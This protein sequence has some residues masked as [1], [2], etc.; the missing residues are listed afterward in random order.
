MRLFIIFF[1]EKDRACELNGGI[2]MVQVE[3]ECIVGA[4]FRVEW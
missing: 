1:F 3:V 4:T 2:Y